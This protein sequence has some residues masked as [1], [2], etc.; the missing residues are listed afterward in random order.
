LHYNSQKTKEHHKEDQHS[1]ELSVVQDTRSLDDLLNFI[2]GPPP[3]SPNG[4]GGHGQSSERKSKSHKKSKP[5]SKKSK[6]KKSSELSPPPSPLSSSATMDTSDKAFKNDTEN[7][8]NNNE[9]ETHYLSIDHNNNNNMNHTDGMDNGA[10]RDNLPGHRFNRSNHDTLAGSHS[11]AYESP[12]LSNSTSSNVSDLS[13]EERLAGDDATVT[14]PEL[15]K[16]IEEFRMRL[17]SIERNVSTIAVVPHLSHF[18]D[19][20][21]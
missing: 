9:A 11:L 8:G 18:V 14:D 2:T 4:S 10:I 15:E 1:K 20:H 19:G 7:C 21:S 17:E 13:D 6:L 3:S 12:S 5:K 16:E